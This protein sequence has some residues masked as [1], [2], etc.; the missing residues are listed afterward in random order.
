[1]LQDGKTIMSISVTSM[2]LICY[3]G[4]T[5]PATNGVNLRRM[6]QPKNGFETLWSQM[7]QT[8]MY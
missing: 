3:T 2:L 8:S 6:R 5:I 7:L 4:S 1:M